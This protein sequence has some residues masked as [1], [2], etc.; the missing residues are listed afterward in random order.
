MESQYIR[1]MALNIG[2]PLQQSYEDGNWQLLQTLATD[3]NWSPDCLLFPHTYYH[4]NHQVGSG[5]SGGVEHTTIVSSCAVVSEGVHNKLLGVTEFSAPVC[6]HVGIRVYCPTD[7]DGGLCGFPALCMRSEGLCDLSGVHNA[8]VEEC[9]TPY[10]R[11]NIEINIG[12]GGLHGN[13]GY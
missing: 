8:K 2:F 4:H 12:V 13:Q 5:V 3:H 1:N 10:M 6:E 9:T 7:P 11:Q